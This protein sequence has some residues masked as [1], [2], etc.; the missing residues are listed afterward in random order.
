MKF[1]LSEIPKYLINIFLAFWILFTIFMF[2]WIIMSS[3]KTTREIYLG[4]WTLPSTF[5][6]TNYINVLTEF[7]LLKSMVNSLIVVSTST[8]LVLVLS[9]P[10][11]YVLSK[12]KFK[13]SN[14]IT[15]SFVIGIGIPIQTI[16]IPLYLLM[17]NLKLTDSLI[18]LIWVYTV[19]SIP[20][21]VYLLINFFNTIPSSLEEAARIDGATAFQS[22]IKIM[23]PL[24]RS[25]L[26]S[27][28]IFV[29]VMLWKEFILALVFIGTESKQP[30][31][32]GLYSLITKLTYTGDWGGL[33][34]GVVLVIIPSVIFYSILARKFIA[35]LT[36]GIGK[37]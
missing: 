25:G 26:I 11:A 20:F 2:G 12:L 34:A 32:L 35:G 17:N 30:I 36:M 28:G 31:S 29:F 10:I 9:T 8:L 23:L 19:T 21:T 3:F 24:A 18:G 37:S 15:F 7:G 33:F 22:F 14:F 5:E 13:L 1:K 4:V 27:A 16:F 6:L